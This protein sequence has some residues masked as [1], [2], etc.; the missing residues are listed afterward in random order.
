MALEIKVAKTETGVLMP[1]TEYDEAVKG[2]LK[3]VFKDYLNTEHAG[4]SMNKIILPSPNP[5]LMPNRKHGRHWAA[6]QQAKAR[7]E[8]YLLSG[9]LKYT[10]GGLKITFY[11][12]DARKRDLDNL[13][14]AMKPALDGMAQ[15]IGVDDALFRPLLIDKVKAESRKAARVEIEVMGQPENE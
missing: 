15:A 9:S 2:S 13:L 11:T 14:A 5:A 1:L 8:A 10:G 4:K 6:T 7:Q 3:A 12:P